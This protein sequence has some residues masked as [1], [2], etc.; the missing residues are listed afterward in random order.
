MVPAGSFL[1]IFV[2][3]VG[4]VSLDVGTLSLFISACKSG[5][6][7]EML[8]LKLS[9]IDVKTDLLLFISASFVWTIITICAL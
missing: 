9:G 2:K 1:F 8:R 3:V 4:P 5:H 7:G 6:V